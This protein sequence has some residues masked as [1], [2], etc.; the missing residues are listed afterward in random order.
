MNSPKPVPKL[1]FTLDELSDRWK[2]S[3]GEL[4]AQAVAG[5]LPVLIP[6]YA[7]AQQGRVVNVMRRDDPEEYP[8]TLHPEWGASLKPEDLSCVA[9]YGAATISVCYH[10]VVSGLEVIS[11]DPP[12]KISTVDL[13]LAADDVELLES[14]LEHPLGESE[15]N[16][17]LK[18]IA[19][20]ALALAGEKSSLYYGG[21]PNAKAIATH[22]L[23]SI[24]NCPAEIKSK[25]QWSGLDEETMRKKIGA[26]MNLLLLKK[27]KH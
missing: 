24:S 26:G 25:I 9:H 12:R 27:T 1:F 21:A 20:M 18:T 11:Y 4:I 5:N 15:R 7:S 23:N 2:L 13:V 19:A 17:L 14:G 16:A 6:H 8:E 22:V 10:Y 3:P